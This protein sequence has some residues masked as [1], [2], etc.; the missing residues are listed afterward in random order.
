MK[1]DKNK[2]NKDNKDKAVKVRLIKFSRS[3]FLV[4][5]YGRFMKT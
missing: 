5:T 1:K 4:Q 3:F 2:D